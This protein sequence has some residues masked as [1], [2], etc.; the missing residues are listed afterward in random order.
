MICSQPST[1][2]VPLPKLSVSILPSISLYPTLPPRQDTSSQTDYFDVYPTPLQPFFDEY[3]D[4][5]AIQR[6]A[7]RVADVQRTLALINRALGR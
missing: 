2:F 4:P 3:T 1:A 6:E 5:M 7:E